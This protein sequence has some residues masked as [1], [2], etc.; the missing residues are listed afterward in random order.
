MDETEPTGGI[1]LEDFAAALA[2]ALADELERR[3]LD[4]SI[5]DDMSMGRSDVT[6]IWQGSASQTAQEKQDEFRQQFA[7]AVKDFTAAVQYFANQQHEININIDES[8]TTPYGQ[9]TR[10]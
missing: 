7:Q 10:Y 4:L 2:C 6:A 3:G 8:G 5:W 9:I 1:K